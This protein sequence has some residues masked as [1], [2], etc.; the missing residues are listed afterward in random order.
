MGPPPAWIKQTKNSPC[1]DKEK[2]TSLQAGVSMRHS[3]IIWVGALF[4]AVLVASLGI[5]SDDSIVGK[6]ADWEVWGVTPKPA[7]EA[8][9]GERLETPNQRRKRLGLPI[10]ASYAPVDPGVLEETPNQR[11]RRLGE[12]LSYATIETAA[13][14]ANQ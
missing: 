9:Q 4:A 8:T 13:N 6:K 7:A 14:V 10:E 1:N 5:A 12:L 11:R 3:K 2:G